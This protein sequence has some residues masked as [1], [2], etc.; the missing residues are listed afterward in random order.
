MAS[1]PLHPLAHQEEHNSPWSP[2]LPSPQYWTFQKCYLSRYLKSF[3][4]LKSFGELW[5][6][7]CIFSNFIKEFAKHRLPWIKGLW[8][9]VAKCATHTDLDSRSFI[10][11]CLITK[12]A[13]RYHGAGNGGRER[14]R[15]LMSTVIANDLGS[16]VTVGGD[17]VSSHQQL[18]RRE[19]ER[20]D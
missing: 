9:S 19:R 8:Q 10:S 18:L 17:V 3:V 7:N 1:T 5:K 12:H 4:K 11:I 16:T 20:G 15:V 13:Q 2:K 6:C 14:E